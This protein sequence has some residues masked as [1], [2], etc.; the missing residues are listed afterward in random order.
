MFIR[1]DNRQ[2][3]AE[4]R[5]VASGKVS[6]ACKIVITAVEL[7]TRLKTPCLSFVKINR[8]SLSPGCLTLEHGVDRVSRNVGN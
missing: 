4:V 5:M 2:V 1:F 3:L 8:I 6:V 7:E